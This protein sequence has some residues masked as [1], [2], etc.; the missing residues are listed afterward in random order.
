MLS[1]NRRI[2]RKLIE[3]T[4]KHGKTV[5]GRN[6]SLKY[7]VDSGKPSGFAFI[8]SSK[9]AKRAVLRNKLKRRGRAAVFGL[10][11]EIKDGCSVL[12]FFEKGS[13]KMKFSEIK[14]EITRLFQKA[15][16]II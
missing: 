7:S 12:I 10:L 16:L 9:T 14:Q 3:K 4:L 13:A 5:R 1:K 11:P 2:P 6:L 15:G 8:V